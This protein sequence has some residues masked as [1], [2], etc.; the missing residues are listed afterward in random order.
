MPQ[1]TENPAL[2]VS[3][4]VEEARTHKDSI[5][6]FGKKQTTSTASPMSLEYSR[7]SP[8]SSVPGENFTLQDVGNHKCINKSNSK[9]DSSGNS[10]SAVSK[11]GGS[12]SRNVAKKHTHP[13]M[14]TAHLKN[15]QLT[16]AVVKSRASNE[17]EAPVSHAHPDEGGFAKGAVPEAQPAGSAVNDGFSFM[18]LFN[19]S[20]FSEFVFFYRSAHYQ[21]D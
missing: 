3:L 20:D 9:P 14:R 5:E 1:R 16:A 8:G 2:L 17:S 18:I 11:T 13:I 10:S 4:S 7:S 21:N 12:I 15:R 19:I 6:N